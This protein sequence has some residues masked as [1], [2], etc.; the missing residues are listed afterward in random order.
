MIAL[1]KGWRTDEKIE[2][3][4]QRIQLGS[5]YNNPLQ[6]LW[7]PDVGSGSLTD[8]SGQMEKLLQDLE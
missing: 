8:R 5:N 3:Q 1:F 4:V 7:W 6:R 2:D